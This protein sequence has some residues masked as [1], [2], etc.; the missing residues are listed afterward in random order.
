MQNIGLK[1]ESFFEESQ[2]CYLLKPSQL[3]E[4]GA[5][6]NSIAN[7]VSNMALRRQFKMIII[8]CK[9]GEGEGGVIGMKMSVTPISPC[10]TT[11]LKSVNIIDSF[12]SLVK[13]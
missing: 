11:S 8:T 9:T 5:G 2:F 12:V 3:L 13:I 10:D 1:K 4:A 6:G 7:S